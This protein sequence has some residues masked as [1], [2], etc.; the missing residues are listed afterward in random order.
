MLLI[1]IVMNIL[2]KKINKIKYIKDKKLKMN[3]MIIKMVMIKIF[4]IIQKE[5]NEI[6]QK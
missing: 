2:I 5:N 1:W 6:K 4:L 3:S